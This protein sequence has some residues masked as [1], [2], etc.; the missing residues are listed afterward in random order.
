[1]FKYDVDEE[2]N[3]F[4]TIY[5]EKLADLV[6]DEVPLLAS[7]KQNG[8]KV[9]VEGAQATMLCNT[10]GTYPLVTSSNCSTGGLIGGL[11]LGWQSIKEV[12]GVVKAYT[13]RVGFGPFPT[14]QINE[15]GSVLQ[16]IGKE[17]GVT[18]GR[19]RRTGWLDLVQ[20]KYTHDI[21]D[22]TCIN[23]TK[24]DILDEFEEIP[25]AVA[26]V[27]AGQELQSFPAST[28]V[29]ESMEVKYQILPGWKGTK[30]SGAKTW[31]ELP[32]NC[33]AYVEFVEK[34]LGVKIKYIGTGKN[35]PQ[36]AKF[37]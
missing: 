34:K 18:T 7:A 21:N 4:K 35:Q 24:L 37:P 17:V 32:P 9:V 12:I 14:E 25:I 22:Y 1:M 29:L 26:Y 2:L 23:L 6:I 13:T 11:S 10:F 33:Q 5:T 31:E 16:R 36:N 3:R 20:V 19:T 27:H 8:W 30:T 28:Q 15:A